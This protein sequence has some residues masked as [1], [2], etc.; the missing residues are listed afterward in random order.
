MATLLMRLVGP[1]QSWGTQSRFSHRDTGREPSKSGV[2]GLLCTALGLPR[3]ANIEDLAGLRM[4]TR[5]DQPGRMMRDFH[6]AGMGGVYKVSGSIKNSLILSERFYLSDAKFLVCLEGDAGLL[7]TLHEALQRPRWLLFL[8]RK[9]FIPSEP[10]WLPEGVVDLPLETCLREYPWLGHH[11]KPPS[12]LQIV[13][14]TPQGAVMRNDHPVSFAARQF[15]PRRVDIDYVPTPLPA[16]DEE[17][18]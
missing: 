14:E 1:M 11:N 7:H 12:S 4:G 17:Q 16:E 5:A 3:D 18:T 6:T 8:G 10:I 2:V 13:V 9:S 15:L